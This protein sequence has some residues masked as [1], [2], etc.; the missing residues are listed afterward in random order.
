[1][2]PHMWLVSKGHEEKMRLQLRRWELFAIILDEWAKPTHKHPS[3]GL[4]LK[5]DLFS[6]KDD[7][8]EKEKMI[9]GKDGPREIT[10]WSRIDV[11]IFFGPKGQGS[12]GIY[13]AYGHIWAQYIFIVEPTFLSKVSATRLRSSEHRRCGDISLRGNNLLPCCR[14]AT[15]YFYTR[16][17]FVT[18]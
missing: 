15:V 5:V 14:V 3:P 17:Q 12:K 4:L 13:M 2:W 7:G 18:S 6:I 16:Q 1:M 9:E 8:E 11:S 10:G